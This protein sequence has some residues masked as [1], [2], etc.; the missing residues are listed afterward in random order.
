MKNKQFGKKPPLYRFILNPYTNDR[1]S[2]CPN[3]NKKTVTKK[4]P[5]FIHIEPVQ[6]V[7]LNKT[8]RYCPFCD[9]LIAHQAD[10]EVQ[11]AMMFEKSNP[12]LIGNDYVVLGTIDYAAWKGGFS[13][14]DL[15]S[16][17]HDFK[18]VLEMRSKYDAFGAKS[19]NASK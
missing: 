15:P 3:C 8:C 5:L 2:R 7:V 6:P 18:E 13:I 11:L 17:L 9:F 4:L 10:L 14:K 1:C 16:Y 19:V 12:R